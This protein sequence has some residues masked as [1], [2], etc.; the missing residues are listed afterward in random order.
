MR[1]AKLTEQIELGLE[2]AMPRPIPLVPFGVFL[3]PAA[4]IALVW[5][6][7]LI[8]WYVGQMLAAS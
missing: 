8:S 2:R 6:Q 1:R 7:S 4:V 3:A 5:G